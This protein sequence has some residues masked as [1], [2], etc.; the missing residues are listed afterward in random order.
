MEIDKDKDVHL[1]LRRHS[2]KAAKVVIDVDKGKSKMGTQDGEA[3]FDVF[4]ISE[5]CMRVEVNPMVKKKTT[6]LGVWK[7]IVGSFK[8]KQREVEKLD[9]YN[10]PKLFNIEKVDPKLKE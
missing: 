1:I 9:D 7:K 10:L 5:E 3:T 2:M 6:K 4:G 8:S